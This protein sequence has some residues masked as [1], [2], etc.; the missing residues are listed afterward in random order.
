MKLLWSTDG[1]WF[2]ETYLLAVNQMREGLYRVLSE[3]VQRGA[4]TVEQSVTI[5]HDLL[6]D[7]ANNIYE[8]E[9][10]L[11]PSEVEAAPEIPLPHPAKGLLS[12]FE[13]FL[14]VNDSVKFLRLQW[15]DY[16]ATLRVRILPVKQAVTMFRES[17]FIGITKAVLGLLQMDLIV[18]GFAA[19]G[20][21]NLVPDFEGLRLSARA[22]HATVFCEFQ[23]KDGSEVDICPRTTLRQQVKKCSDAGQAFLVGFEIEVVFMR[24]S[25]E[26]LDVTFGKTPLTLQGGHAWSA[27][28]ALQSSEIMDVVE[29]IVSK[30]ESVGIELLQFHPETAPGQYEF[31][32]GPQPPVAAV[33]TLLSAREIIRQV[34]ADAGLRAT[35]Y[36]KPFPQTCGNGAHI[37]LSLQ[38][39]TN[40]R[41]F[42]AGVLAH[43]RDMSA[44]LYANEA[45]YERAVD[46]AWAGSS[47]ITW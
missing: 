19:T 15:L 14:D 12:N 40:W 34:A 43:L 28:Q 9:L 30:L 18:E 37:H 31:V 38:P 29:S 4:L 2:P 20:E 32:L 44:L 11:T 1:H 5:V 3:Y 45:S 27:A 13:Q 47:W 33:D 6:F 35:L 7:T 41:N 25:V 24:P 8:L 23:E 26:D 17:R 46:G 42:Y 22:G 39:D 10:E 21:Y 16:T 36:P